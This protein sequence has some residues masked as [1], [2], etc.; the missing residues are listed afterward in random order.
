MPL[1]YTHVY[2]RERERLALTADTQGRREKNEGNCHGRWTFF[3]V[4]VY[5]IGANY[6]YR[7]VLNACKKEEEDWNC[8]RRF[9]QWL[10]NHC[11]VLLERRFQSQKSFRRWVMSKLSRTQALK[12]DGTIWK[13]WER[14]YLIPCKAHTQP[15][16]DI[17]VKN[18]FES[19]INRVEIAQRLT[20]WFLYS[21]IN[22]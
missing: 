12:W 8:R 10:S 1:V 21:L 6:I 9:C 17:L 18:V 11:I 5:H 13:E 19:D 16:K 20:G 22:Q 15:G 3:L 14:V 2:K 7:G 4:V